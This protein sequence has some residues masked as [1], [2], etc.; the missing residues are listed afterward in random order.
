MRSFLWS[1]VFLLF[2]TI[3]MAFAQQAPPP[4]NPFDVGL[5]VGQNIPRFQ[6]KSQ[7]GR[8]LDFNAVRGPNGLALLFF[9]SA[10]W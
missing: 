4:K 6:L 8:E 9:R 3:T 5:R 1:T 10:D 7:N 2:L